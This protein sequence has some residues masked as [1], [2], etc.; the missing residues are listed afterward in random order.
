MKLRNPQRRA[1]RRAAFTL[2]EMM[3]VVAIIVALAGV[4]IFYMAG[5]ADEGN[6]AKVKAN[7]KSLTDACVIYKTQHNGMWPNQLSDLTVGPDQSGHGPYVQ[8]EGILDPWGNPYQ[9]DQ[10]GQHNQGMTPDIYCQ[11]QGGLGTIGN[12]TSRLIK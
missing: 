5:Q 1:L 2:M 11:M 4:G 12:W 10:S 6:K 3:V 9:Y 8:A 7:I